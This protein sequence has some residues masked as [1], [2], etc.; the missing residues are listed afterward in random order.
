MTLYLK[1]RL[2]KR[3]ESHEGA[4]VLQVGEVLTDPFYP[5]NGTDDGEQY[6]LKNNTCKGIPTEGTCSKAVFHFLWKLCL[7]RFVVNECQSHEVGNYYDK[8]LNSVFYLRMDQS[9]YF[10]FLINWSRPNLKRLA[11][12]WSAY[13]FILSI[14]FSVH[15]TEVKDILDETHLMLVRSVYV[16][17]TTKRTPEVVPIHIIWKE[18]P[19][20]NRKWAIS[21][22]ILYFTKIMVC[23]FLSWYR[24]YE[25][26][27]EHARY[28]NSSQCMS[29]KVITKCMFAS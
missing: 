6:L 26:N 4:V 25:R 2:W 27:T 21:Y 3:D 28:Y 17:H 22:I 16:L 5:L 11:M 23:Y 13:L 18:E 29:V 24:S 7:V 14:G 9:I 10:S 20:E 8:P 12:I 15:V 19:P 1:P